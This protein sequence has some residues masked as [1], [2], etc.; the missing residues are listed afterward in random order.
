MNV[1]WL[2]P[3]IAAVLPPAPAAFTEVMQ[4]D[5]VAFKRK[6][7]HRTLRVEIA[8]RGFFLKAHTGVGWGNILLDLLRGRR[9]LLG[10]AD[11]WRAIQRVQALGIPTLTL[12]GYGARG[13]NP[14]RLHSFVLTDELTDT[15]SLEQLT[16]DWGTR[17]LTQEEVRLKRTL[18]TRV[19]EIGRTLHTNGVNH[20]DF[21]LCH[22][23]LDRRQSPLLYLIDLHRVQLR[24][25]TPWRWQVKDIGALWFSAQQ[26]GLTRRDVYR[27]LRVYRGKSL[28]ASL[29]E[30]AAF[31]T[32][33]QARAQALRQAVKVRATP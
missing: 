24:R 14:A 28:R 21:Y 9:P 27:F 5:G 32:A 7:T 33:V 29:Q 22:F 20:R 30:D 16:A 13:G 6:K 4:L 8:G 31:W 25:T 17:R 1:F 2:R 19:A 11:E 15:V 10:A 18:L 3:D 26:I 23:L 12:A